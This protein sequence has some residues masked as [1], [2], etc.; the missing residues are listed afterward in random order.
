MISGVIEVYYFAQVHLILEAKF[1]DEPRMIKVEGI[2]GKK[3]A[4]FCALRLFPLT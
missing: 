1:Y 3:E 4:N 2:I